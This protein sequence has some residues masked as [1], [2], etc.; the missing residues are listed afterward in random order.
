MALTGTGIYVDAV[1]VCVCVCVCSW[2]LLWGVNGFMVCCG[3]DSVYARAALP[4]AQSGRFNRR[5][6]MHA[7]LFAPVT[8]LLGWGLDYGFIGHHQSRALPLERSQLPRA[9]GLTA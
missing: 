6:N 1:G 7:Y 8:R 4:V 9:C 2:L 5:C 3:L